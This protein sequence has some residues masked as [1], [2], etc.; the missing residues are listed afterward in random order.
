MMMGALPVCC[1]SSASEGGSQEGAAGGL[2]DR[3][4]FVVI[5]RTAPMRVRASRTVDSPH[6]SG[7]LRNKKK[8][9]DAD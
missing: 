5:L 4:S 7:L 2:R 6:G 8:F 3:T 1:E 9:K